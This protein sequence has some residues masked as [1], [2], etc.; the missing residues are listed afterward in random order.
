ME[1]EKLSVVIKS[2]GKWSQ[3]L[4]EKLSSTT[5]G[6]HLQ[7]SLEGPYGPASTQFLRHDML[8]IVSGGSGIT[9]F[10]SI[11][12]ELIYIAGST[13]CKIPKVLLVAT[14]KKSADLAM[15]DLLLPLSGTTY[16]ILRL[17]LQ[18]E[19]YVT[20]EKEPLKDKLLKTLWLKPNASERPVSV[21]LG[22]NNWLWL[23][24][25]I[26]SSFIMFLLLIGILNR[27]YIYPADHNTGM[28][29][30]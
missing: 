23:G 17:Q 15:L 18:I 10:I 24:A 29:D 1:P 5:L 28:I 21:V 14:F 26:T 27:Y 22:Q 3:K 16:D 4:F 9:P 19:A 20:R 11:I 13:S 12:R 8:V 30:S 25:I 7:V 2:E 6:H